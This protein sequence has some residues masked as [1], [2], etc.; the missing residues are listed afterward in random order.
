MKYTVFSGIFG[1][2][3]LDDVEK[4][5]FQVAV[6]SAHKFIFYPTTV[7]G[8]M[9]ISNKVLVLLFMLILSCGSYTW[10][11]AVM[12]LCPTRQDVS[13]TLM[14]M[15]S[16][17]S[18]D[19]R[20]H[21]LGAFS[22][23]GM[24]YFFPSKASPI[25]RSDF[26]GNIS[27]EHTPDAAWFNSFPD[28]NIAGYPKTGTSQLYRILAGH[29]RIASANVVK[30]FCYRGPED[31]VQNNLLAR[32]YEYRKQLYLHRLELNDTSKLTVNG[33]LLGSI[34]AE[35]N[36]VYIPQR[37]E[38]FIV[39]YRDPADWLWAA[40]NFW[41]DRSM[42]N[43]EKSDAITTAEK[44]FRSPELF[45]EIIAS[46]GKLILFYNIFVHLQRA[47][48]DGT[49]MIELVGRNNVLFLR[50]EDIEPSTIKSSGTLERLSKFLSISSSE[51]GSEILER[52]NCNDVKGENEICP[53]IFTPGLYKTAGYRPML[54]KTRVLIYAF[55]QSACTFWYEQYEIDYPHCRNFITNKHSSLTL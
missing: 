17:S 50:N 40:W 12:E 2:Q 7:P 45:H 28:I 13:E 3:R 31:N 24:K 30:E 33:C 52:T 48:W 35:V 39:M 16:D 55:S 54:N 51:F 49:R 5:G 10:L 4:Q 20:M 42:D 47:T 9:E 29:S 8:S 25:R 11:W 27:I 38:K 41:Y 21:N 43:P 23:Q 15:R 34:N 53:K 37:G 46:K 22:E 26:L 14:V 32:L 44:N 18:D 19:V 1:S 6:H 36:Y